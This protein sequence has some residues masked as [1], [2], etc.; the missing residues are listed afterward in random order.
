MGYSCMVGGGASGQIIHLRFPNE[1]SLSYVELTYLLH[2][3]NSAEQRP[4]KSS[5]AV[6]KISVIQ[7]W[8]KAKL[9]E[10][11]DLIEGWKGTE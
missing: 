8:S 11:V 7:G 1:S 6:A 5:P 9:E 3:M 10:E 2:A 4:R